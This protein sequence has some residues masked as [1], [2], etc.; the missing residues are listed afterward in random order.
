M[1]L[2]LLFFKDILWCGPLFKVFTEFVIILFLFYFLASMI[3]A[4]QPDT[5]P[6]PLELEGEVLTTEPPGK[7]L[8]LVTFNYFE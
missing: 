3:L 6:T 7:S 1:S 5:E 8:I 4:P 2:I